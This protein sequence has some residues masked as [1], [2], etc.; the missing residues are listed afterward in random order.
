LDGIWNQLHQHDCGSYE[1]LPEPE[2]ARLL[3]TVP[4]VAGRRQTQ[5]QKRGGVRVN[6]DHACLQYLNNAKDFT[7]SKEDNEK[8]NS[9]HH[10]SAQ[11]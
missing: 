8:L 7:R 1:L 4:S 11:W 6:K 2:A 5:F 9:M 3:R 10:Q